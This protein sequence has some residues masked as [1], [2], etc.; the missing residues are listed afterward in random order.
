MIVV[1]WMNNE[2]NKVIEDYGGKIEGPVVE[3]EAKKNKRNWGV[4]NDKLNY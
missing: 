2:Q 1:T 3:V 4:I